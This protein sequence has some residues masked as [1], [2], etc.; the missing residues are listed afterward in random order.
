MQPPPEYLGSFYLG[1]E[2]D[3]ESGQPTDIPLNYDSR[4][5][6]THAICVGMTGSGKTGLCL[7]LLEEA[8]IDRVPAILIDPKGDIS[9]LAL[10]FPDLNPQDFMAWISPEEA[11]QAGKNVAEVAADVAARWKQGL[12]DWGMGPARLHTLN[13]S[14]DYTI[15]TPGSDAGVPVNILGSLAAPG[16]NFDEQA[17]V[18]RE[19]IGG[20]VNALLGFIG[21]AADPVQSRETIL[22]STIFEHFWRQ[23][24][25]LDL[26]KLILAL[27]HPPVRQ[28]GVLDV[29][30]FYPEK[31]RFELAM[32]FNNLLAS[33]TFQNWLQG[34]DLDISALLYTSEGKPRHS[35]FY[36]AH[37]SP[38]ERMFFV[39]LLLESVLAWVRRQS[40]TPSL[41]AILY[42]D[43]VYGYLPPVAQPASKRPLMA[44]L[45]Q[46]R[47]AG[48]G[49]VLATQNPAD[50]DYKA[51]TN[52]GTWFIGRLQAERDKARVMDG[53]KDAIAESG[54]DSQRVDYEQVIGQ[55]GP[56]I[57][58]LHNVHENVPVIFQSRWVMSYL[59]GPLTRPQ[60]QALTRQ[61]RPHSQAA[62][63][64]TPMSP[65][66]GL[67]TQDSLQPGFSAARQILDPAIPQ[68]F[69]PLAGDETTAVQDFLHS[70]GGDI[71]ITNVQ[72]IYQAAIIGAASIGFFDRNQDIAEQRER[73]LLAAAPDQLG[74]IDWDSATP[75]SVP[76]NQLDQ[77]PPR[78][79]SAQG[80][81]FASVPEAANSPAELKAI[82]QDLE[83]WLYYHSQLTLLSHPELGIVQQANEE[84]RQFKLR[85]RQAARERRDAAVDKLRRSYATRMEK[86]DAKLRRQERDLE[87]DE[88][89]YS[90]RK[91]EAMIATGEMLFTWLSRRRAYRSASWTASRRRLAKHARL[92]LEESREEIEDLETELAQLQQELDAEIAKIT[93]RWVD[94]LKGLTSHAIRPRRSDVEVRLVGLAWVPAWLIGYTRAGQTFASTLPAYRVPEESDPPPQIEG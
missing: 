15:Y 6:T 21:I 52:T 87:Q 78:L 80:P 53:L 35:I 41:R 42:F 61:G 55:L 72:L 76:L 81:F 62:P 91:R 5:L 71:Q 86:L 73:V 17:E 3:L 7:G 25:D 32:A 43:E 16:L 47:A 93:P 19:R 31:D 29:D 82:G 11:Q 12:E 48:L 20:T 26:T 28:L 74:A 92:E 49:C 54:R 24:Q 30:T 46:G 44:L 8:A 34:D 4:Q 27:Q 1:A 84:E 85:L 33:P 45:K 69:L 88:F 68:L 22:L 67:A 60:I 75:L 10:Q 9:N 39:T 89:D 63:R 65:V 57:F 66:P 2:Y 64:S 18:I 38:Q 13:E 90:A 58:L 37:L 70:A 83:D 36:I 23:N 77:A 40:G 59:H 94:I 50:I 79:S 51:L 14:V 56:R